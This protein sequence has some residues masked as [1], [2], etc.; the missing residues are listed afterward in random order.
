[1]T[2]NEVL[3]GKDVFHSS[4]FQPEKVRDH[5]FWLGNREGDEMNADLLP[6]FFVR[7]VKELKPSISC[8]AASG[9]SPSPAMVLDDFPRSELWLWEKRCSR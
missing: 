4:Q 9:P 8:I 3:T 1:M 2:R 7:V 5:I 6:C